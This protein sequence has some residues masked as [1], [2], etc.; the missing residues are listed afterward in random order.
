M[1]KGK[2]ASHLSRDPHMMLAM[3]CK[4]FATDAGLVTL[5]SSRVGPQGGLGGGGGAIEG[6]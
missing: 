5:K 2:G 1:Q 4:S 3:E 6:T